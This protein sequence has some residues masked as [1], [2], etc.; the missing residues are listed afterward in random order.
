MKLLKKNLAENKTELKHVRK[1]MKR[2]Q[3][4]RAAKIKT[5]ARLA[6]ARKKAA[7]T[8]S[9]L[10]KQMHLSHWKCLNK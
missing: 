7:E 4:Q 3:I 9:S 10:V 6:A 5:A 1:M 2:N 8:F